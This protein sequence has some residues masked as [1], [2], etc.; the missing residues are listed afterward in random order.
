MPAHGFK[1]KPLCNTVIQD[2]PLPSPSPLHPYLTEREKSPGVLSLSRIRKAPFIFWSFNRSSAFFL[3]MRPLYHLRGT[4]TC[5]HKHMHTQTHAYT[6]TCTHVRTDVH[7]CMHTC[8]NARTHTHLYKCVHLQELRDTSCTH[9]R[10]HT[11]THSRTHTP[12]HMCTLAG[13]QPHLMHTYTHTHASTHSHHNTQL[14]CNY[15]H[16][17]HSA[18]LSVHK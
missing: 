2:I 11:R 8:T 17:W 14:G 3:V 16:S 7:T 15:K 10:T 4:H 5:I 13:T 1:L 12:L 18:Q 6:N 9:A